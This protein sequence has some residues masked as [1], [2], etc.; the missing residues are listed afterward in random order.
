MAILFEDTLGHMESSDS[1]G[2]NHRFGTG[3]VHR[4]LAGR[5]VRHTQTP[6][7]GSRIHAVQMFIDLPPVLRQ[8]PVQ[9][10]HLAARDVPIHAGA[11]F[12]IRL[13]VGEAFGLSSPLKLPQNMLIIEGWARGLHH[14]AG[15]QRALPGGGFS[16]VGYGSFSAWPPRDTRQRAL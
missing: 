2:T 7:S 14:G 11:D 4:T 9:T 15:G 8:A 1:V 13:L 16:S 3:D 5:G 10:F 12:R 6:V